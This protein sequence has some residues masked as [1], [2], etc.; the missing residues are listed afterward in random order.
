MLIID[1]VVKRYGAREVLRGVSFAAEPGKVTA[2]VGPNGSGKS[3]LLHAI[4]G[5][6]RLHAGEI[7]VDGIVATS[8]AGRAR[9]GFAPDDLPMPELLTAREYLDLVRGARGVRVSQGALRQM[10]AGLRIDDSLDALVGS[11]S[12]G[13]KRKLQ[14]IAS[15]SHLPHVLVLDEPFRG[16]D[17]ESAAIMRQLVVRLAEEGGTVL[18]STHDLPLAQRLCE[19]VVVLHDG[20]IAADG[21]T[22]EIIGQHG[23]LEASFL[24]HTGLGAAAEASADTFFDGY[25]MLAARA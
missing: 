5:L 15:L 25:R 9:I 16:L 22:D 24:A 1:D 4:V 13:M 23:D 18:F 10:A 6:V 2:L 20:V 17:P 19:R 3:T 11:F 7:T 21:A 8:S 14:L 12:H